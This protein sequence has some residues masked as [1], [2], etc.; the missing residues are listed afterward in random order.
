MGGRDRNLQGEF[1]KSSAGN[2]SNDFAVSGSICNAAISQTEC[3]KDEKRA[4]SIW[5]LVDPYL[6]ARDCPKDLEAKEQLQ[7]CVLPYH[8]VKEK[9]RKFLTA[10][11]NP[12][13]TK[14][15]KKATFDDF[16]IQGTDAAGYVTTVRIGQATCTGEEFRK[17]WNYLPVIFLFRSRKENCKLLPVESGTESA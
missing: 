6:P 16:E 3:R 10:V 2:R 15:D 13:E 14:E 17:H 9:C 5:K 11:E 7:E 12:E 1:E 4:G 8:K